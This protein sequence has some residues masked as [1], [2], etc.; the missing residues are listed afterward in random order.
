MESRGP[1]RTRLWMLAAAYAWLIVLGFVSLS[2]GNVRF[3]VLAVLALLVIA[4]Y[5][6]LWIALVTALVAGVALPMLDVVRPPHIYL[7]VAW[8]SATLAITLCAIVF[9]AEWLRRLSNESSHLRSR[10]SRAEAAAV[11]DSLTGMPN[12]AYFIERL[13]A[14]IAQASDANGKL[15][16]L[17]ADL[18]GF[19]QI[20]DLHGHAMGD[21]VLVLAARR[22]SHAL[23]TED[24]VAR[25]GGDE[26]SLIVRNV[27]D[28]EEVMRVCDV[29]ESA[30]RAPFRCG[31]VDAEIGI[32]I[33]FSLFPDDALDA[34][35]L[36]LQ[37]DGA[38][39]ARKRQ[40]RVGHIP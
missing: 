33:G 38:M 2:V 4:F 29:L 40:K 20:N 14:E 10:V 1:A 31:D 3:G 24:V 36:L 25:I 35:G 18:D 30:F 6:R 9:V 19:K 26:F 27:H 15:A 34:D 7:S 17:F 13:R 16:V 23:R 39:Y 32:T 5:S 37:S 11:L 12:R 28:R 21:R 22:L 8:E